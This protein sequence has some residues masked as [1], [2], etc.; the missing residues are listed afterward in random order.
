MPHAVIQYWIFLSWSGKELCFYA[1]RLFI[2]DRRETT[3]L[4]GAGCELG[5]YITYSNYCRCLNAVRV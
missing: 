4:V 3:Y 5:L 2:G 1:R